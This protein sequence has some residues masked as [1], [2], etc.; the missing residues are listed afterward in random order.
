MAIQKDIVVN[1]KEYERIKRYD[2]NQMN[3]YVKSIYKSGFEDS[4]AVERGGKS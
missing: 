1:R 3:N 2:H 4:K